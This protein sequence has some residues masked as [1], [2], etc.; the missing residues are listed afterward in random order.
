[1]QNYIIICNLTSVLIEI[2]SFLLTFAAKIKYQY[3]QTQ[4]LL[5]ATQWQE[6]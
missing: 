3:E 4:D 2:C 1:M 6:Q 5:S